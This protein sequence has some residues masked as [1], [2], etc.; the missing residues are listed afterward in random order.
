MH[1]IATIISDSRFFRSLEV[2][3]LLHGGSALPLP[4]IS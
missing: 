3:W 4:F 1:L 2:K